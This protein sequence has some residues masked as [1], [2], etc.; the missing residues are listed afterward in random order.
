M[1]PLRTL[2]GVDPAAADAHKR[3][4]LQKIVLT[5]V[6]IVLA[7]VGFKYLNRMLEGRSKSP[8]L[9]RASRRAAAERREDVYDTE[10]C[11]VCGAYVPARQPPACG[12]ADCP[13]R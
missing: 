13:Y 2:T 9:P 1:E 12:R 11:A 5:I 6:L 3:G 8:D 4:M 7:W 10:K